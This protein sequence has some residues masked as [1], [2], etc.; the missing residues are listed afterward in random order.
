MKMYIK[1]VGMIVGA[2]VAQPAWSAGSCSNILGKW[3]NELQSIMTIT[4]VDAATGRIDGTYS[5]PSGTA[6]ETFNLIGW[7]NTTAPDPKKDVVPVLTFSVRWT[8]YGSAT[9]WTG[10]CRE[11][12]GKTVIKTVWHL[13]RPKADFPFEH[14]LVGADV[15]T[16][17]P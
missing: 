8:P 6:G 13:A 15:F 7:L 1:I 4:S 16:A 9:A 12:A 11:I 5:S 3:T 14:V 10:T 17:A 2:S